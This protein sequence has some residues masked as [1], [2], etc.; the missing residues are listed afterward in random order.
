[1][2]DELKSVFTDTVYLAPASGHDGVGKSNSFGAEK[3]YAAR[4][5]RKQRTVMS[6]TAKLAISCAQIWFAP[7][8]DPIVVNYG[9]KLRLPDGVL[10]NGNTTTA[11]LAIDSQPDEDGNQ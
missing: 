10:P 11:I 2:F 5:S 1:M 8:A 3:S 9:D 6:K 4:I 7:C